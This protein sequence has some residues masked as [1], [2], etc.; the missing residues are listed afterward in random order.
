[1]SGWLCAGAADAVAS[2]AAQ[3]GSWEV[4]LVAEALYGRR[5]G[6]WSLLAADA[7]ALS[8]PGPVRGWAA[9]AS[10]ALVWRAGAQ[11]RGEDW[12]AGAHLAAF[13]SS[14]SAAELRSA[15]DWLPEPQPASSTVA[16]G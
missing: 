3:L 11:G 2:A 1:M 13:A 15:C 5:A 14:G 9:T 6:A 10:D 8:G 7:Q 12:A 16:A 4:M